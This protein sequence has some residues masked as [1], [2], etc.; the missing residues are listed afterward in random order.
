MGDST[1][2]VSWLGMQQ[3]PTKWDCG[4]IFSGSPAFEDVPAK[5]WHIFSEKPGKTSMRI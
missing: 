2:G 1:V 5:I 3:I 4:R